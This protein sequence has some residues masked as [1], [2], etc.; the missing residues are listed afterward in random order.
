MIDIKTI[1]RLYLL[2]DFVTIITCQS[3]DTRMKFQELKKI[4]KY[5]KGCYCEVNDICNKLKKNNV[6]NKP[7]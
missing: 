6:K 1:D 7:I 4:H 5:I 2:F 3:F